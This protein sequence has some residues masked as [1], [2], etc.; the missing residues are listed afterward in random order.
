MHEIKNWN[1]RCF[2]AVIPWP[3]WNEMSL[4]YQVIPKHD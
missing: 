3:N 1:I 2:F 4:F